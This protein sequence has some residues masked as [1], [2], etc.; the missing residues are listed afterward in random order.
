[1]QELGLRKL[2]PVGNIQ[3]TEHDPVDLTTSLQDAFQELKAIN[4]NIPPQELPPLKILK[5]LVETVVSRG[6]NTASMLFLSMT[7]SGKQGRTKISLDQILDYIPVISWA[8]DKITATLILTFASPPQANSTLEPI[9]SSSLTLGGLVILQIVQKVSSA[10][11]HQAYQKAKEA[12][13]SHEAQTTVICVSLVVVHYLE[14][15]EIGTSRRYSSFTHTVVVGIGK[16]GMIV[17][18]SLG[19]QED[20]RRA[21]HGFNLDEYPA[22]NG[23]HVRS[24]EEADKFVSAFT[25]LV[26]GSLSV[27]E[28]SQENC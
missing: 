25:K 28:F 19:E 27:L 4:R 22:L 26:S 23:G 16:P 12:A 7:E 15:A 11:F 8:S 10:S 9:N 2:D 5:L 17:W 6:R 21:Q 20:R 13:L 3:D 14:L 1:M 18:Q 24:W